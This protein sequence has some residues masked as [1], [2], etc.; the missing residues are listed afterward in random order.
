MRILF[1]TPYVPSRIRVRPLNLIKSLSQQHD[2]SLVSLLV[3]DYERHLVSD[4]AD[5]CVSLDLVLLPKLQAY[6]NCLLAL[7]TRMPLLVAYYRSPVFSQR[8]EH[9]IHRQNI[10]V[11]HAELIKVIPALR[12]M[13]SVVPPPI[14]FDSVDC[15]SWL[16]QQ[17]L[18]RAHNPL[19]KLFFYSEF[20]KMRHYEG[21]ELANFEQL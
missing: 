16:L 21:S 1:V 10:D 20:Q 11:I 4:V 17:K 6:A 8:L 18:H 19:K 5:F 7:P 3:D 12:G 9:I 2:I 14:L 13:Q 15:I